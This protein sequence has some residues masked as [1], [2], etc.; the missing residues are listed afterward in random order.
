MVF[1]ITKVLIIEILVIRIFIPDYI[2]GSN[3]AE[4][5]LADSRYFQVSEIEVY[6]K[7]QN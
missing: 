7:Q 1:V 2:Y 5:F 6:T 4:S 3:E